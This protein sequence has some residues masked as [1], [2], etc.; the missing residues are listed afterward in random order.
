MRRMDRRALALRLTG[1]LAMGALL[2]TGL[3]I[4]LIV[5]NSQQLLE[6]IAHSAAPRVTTIVFVSMFM[7]ICA[8]GASITGFLFMVAEEE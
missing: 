7:L 5:L 1:H 2:G 4:A 6:M 8:V 3:A